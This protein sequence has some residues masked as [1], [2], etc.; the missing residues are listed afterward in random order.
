MMVYDFSDKRWQRLN[1]HGLLNCSYP[2]NPQSALAA[3]RQG[4]FAWYEEEGRVQWWKPEMR[5]VF[6]TE[7]L[8][9]SRSTRKDWKQ[10][11]LAG[12]LSI[13][14]DHDFASV[15][16]SCA[17]VHAEKEGATWLLPEMQAVYQALHEEGYAH[18]VE[19]WEEGRLVG[20]VYGVALGAVFCAESMFHQRT[21]A[22]KIALWALSKALYQRGIWVIEAQFLTEHL[23]SLGA[24]WMKAWDYEQLLSIDPEKH[25][26]LWRSS[27]GV[28][29]LL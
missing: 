5:A 11:A 9:V 2:L 21:N 27:M 3:H 26:G 13:T 1:E 24:R 8:H 20:G 6:L 14:L 15:M 23:Y 17:R 12:K 25:R 22:S 4:A 16:E 29:D 28:E 18:S 19:V 7:A 10:S